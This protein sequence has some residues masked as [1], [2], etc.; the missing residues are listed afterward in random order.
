[1]MTFNNTGVPRALRLGL[2][3][4]AALL[5]VSGSANAQS[6]TCTRTNGPALTP[7]AALD[8]LVLGNRRFV[9]DAMLRRSMKC[10]RD[11]TAPGQRP[12]A[13]VLSCMDSRAPAEMLFD[14]GPGEIFSLRVAG[15]VLS[16]D[17]L[18]SMEYAAEHVG[19]KLIAVI[20][21]TRCGAMQGACE[22]SYDMSN[23]TDLLVKIEPAYQAVD[24]NKIRRNC[25]DTNFIKA[26]TIANVLYTMDQI[27]KRSIV[28]KHM[29]ETGAVKLVAGIYNVE[30]GVTT[31]GWSYK[32]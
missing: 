15:N 26:M 25:A 10:A 8:S 18:G 20:G 6:G 9:L 11:T 16:N 4:V 32:P 14:R 21:H 19:V 30:T 23:L 31:F 24:T 17:M 2:L 13:I 28:L 5:L 7:Q 29:L 22:H 12:F 27:P 3:C 1:M